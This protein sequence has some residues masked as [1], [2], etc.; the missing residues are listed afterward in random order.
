[1]NVHSRCL[2][3]SIGAARLFPGEFRGVIT[4]M[5]SHF[6]LVVT[7]SGNRAAELHLR[8]MHGG[9]LAYHRA[10]FASLS[11]LGQRALLDLRGYILCY[12][13]PGREAEEVAEVGV[14]I[15]RDVLG[16]E[17]FKRLAASHSERT[18]RVQ[19]P[20]ATDPDSFASALARIPWEL[21]CA[22]P[23]ERTLA[24]RN[25]RIRIVHDAPTSDS[26]PLPLVDGEPLKIL[27]VFADARGSVPLNTRRERL[28]L[29]ELFDR[30]RRQHRVEV[31][32]LSHGVTRARLRRQI[33]SRSGYHIVHWNGHGHRNRLELARANGTRD[34]LSGED[35]VHLFVDAGGYLPRLCFLGAC[36]SG[37]TLQIYD[38]DSFL[39]AARDDPRTA[40]P[41]Q[42]DPSAT[43]SY[44]GTAH[45]L[46]AGGVPSVVAMRQAVGDEYTR[47]LAVAFYNHLLADADMKTVATALALARNKLL[48]APR[49]FDA[50][51]HASPVLYG[52]DDPDLAPSPGSLPAPRTRYPIPIAAL[53]AAHHVDFVGR[54]RELAD[55][56][57][58]FIGITDGEPAAVA[59]ISG[60]GGMGK[61]AFA[62]EALNLWDRRFEW[63]L[64]LQCKDPKPFDAA[65][66]ELHISLYAEQGLYF[67]RVKAHPVDAFHRDATDFPGPNRLERLTRN[68]LLALKNESILLVL[69]NFE[70]NLKPISEP[71]A[72]PPAWACQ[73]PA[74]DHAL[75]A[76]ADGLKDGPSR[77]LVTSRHPLAALARKAVH[78]SVLGPLPAGEAA[79]FLKNHAGLRT[80]SFSSEDVDRQLARRVL[81]ASRFHPLLMDRLA[82]QVS[83][84]PRLFATLGKLETNASSAQLVDLFAADPN[85]SRERDYLAGA[86]TASLDVLLESARPDGR[87][88]LW[89][90]SVANEPVARDL[91]NSIWL[92]EDAG[93]QPPSAFDHPLDR[94]TAVGLVTAEHTS[95]DDP[96][97]ELTCH[98]LV[99]ERIQDR[100]IHH[101]TERGT[102]TVNTI[103]L[104]YAERLAATYLQLRHKDMARALKA[105][106]YALVYCVQAG[107]HDRLDQFASAVITGARD[108]NLLAMLL[109]YLESAAASAP[110]GKPRSRCLLYL[111]DT[112]RLS[113]NLQESLLRYVQAADETRIIAESS[114]ADAQRAWSDLSVIYGNWALSLR[115]LGRHTEARQRHVDSTDASRKANLPAVEIL[116]SEMEVLRIDIFQKG[117]D[118]A[119]PDIKKRLNQVESW[120]ERHQKGESVSEAPNV[121][122]LARTYISALDIADQAH[123]SKD[124]WDECLQY[125]DTIIAVK[126]LIHRRDED[127]GSDRLNRAIVL[128]ALNRLDE[129]RVELETCLRLFQKDPTRRART[130]SV[131]AGSCDKQGDRRQ[132]IDLARQ[133][134]ALRDNLPFPAERASCHNDL[135]IYLKKRGAPSDYEE[136]ALHQYA[137]L[138][139]SLATD[140]RQN[141]QITLYNYAI[142]F[143]FARR[144]STSPRIPTVVE[145]LANPAYDPLKRW[146][147]AHNVDLVALQACVDEFLESARQV[148]ITRE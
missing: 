44:T 130:L 32:V 1:M 100:M 46:L 116:G 52:A 142:Y 148:S 70:T 82:R 12:G 107:A 45:A 128:V 39:A 124:E 18:L 7:A 37:D 20:G 131:L 139:Y 13:S 78:S 104:A 144:D 95:P 80:L 43:P 91:L 35:L 84:R 110:E 83:D 141:F 118:T 103:R 47:E 68:L 106:H 133:A 93:M 125:I 19:L 97:P 123:R 57:A 72:D 25:L 59:M 5:A 14:S 113:N 3:G 41:A 115:A 117:P 134:L 79:L 132:A 146:L 136:A 30:V 10:D 9:H 108:P 51:D 85:D 120:W 127:I 53:T 65:L 89:M 23:R 73:D 4:G 109:P 28:A 122:V 2:G 55:L 31:D 34:D 15:A 92:T 111:A 94:L 71:S 138:L 29:L 114:D 67:D 126:V 87:R 49:P 135:S 81:T 11:P 58:R 143:N 76:L 21:A 112:L 24:R 86:L 26:T 42:F 145:I 27:L 102:W 101:P 147:D 119:L 48:D 61:T 33:E 6:D 50:C 56:G 63:V 74:W 140:H 137:D 16:N 38:W 96:N 17:I 90:L 64:L 88:L 62:A 8:D 75:A 69:D 40:D 99:R 77:L 98:E 105:G 22:S 121:E 129:A 54:T 60:P 36:Q 66:R